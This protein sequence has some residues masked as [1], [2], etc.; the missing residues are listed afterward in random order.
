[1]IRSAATATRCSPAVF[2]GIE[3][4][5]DETYAWGWEELY[6]IE[7]TMRRRRGRIL[8][9]ESVAR[10]PTTSTTTLTRTVEGVDEFQQWNQE[11]IDRTIAELNGTHFDI[12]AAVAPVRGDDLAAR[13]RG[14]DVLHRPERGLQPARAHV[15]PDAGQARRS[16]SGVR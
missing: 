15:V 13:R 6:R 1:M 4:D 10:S 16:R 5:L 8:P 2:S 11:L 12:A 3:L 9:G 14:R 7:D